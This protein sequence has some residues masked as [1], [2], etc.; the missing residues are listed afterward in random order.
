MW[1]VSPTTHSAKLQLVY[2]LKMSKTSALDTF[3]IQTFYLYI[4]LLHVWMVATLKGAAS[5][6]VPAPPPLNET[7]FIIFWVLISLS[8]ELWDVYLGRQ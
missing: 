6:Q 8:V 7:L 2:G 3:T 1:D 4:H 5:F